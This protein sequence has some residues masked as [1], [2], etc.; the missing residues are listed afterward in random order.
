[1]KKNVTAKD[2]AK[3]DSAIAQAEEIVTSLIK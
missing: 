2:I 1:M 3:L